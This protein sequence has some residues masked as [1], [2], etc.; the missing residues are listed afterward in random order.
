MLCWEMT[1]GGEGLL[2]RWTV[3]RPSAELLVA[4]QSVGQ[5]RVMSQEGSPTQA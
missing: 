4:A 2:G 3:W 5:R 1:G